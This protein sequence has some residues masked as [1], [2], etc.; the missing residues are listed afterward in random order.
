MGLAALAC[1]LDVQAGGVIL[2]RSQAATAA[3]CRQGGV[4]WLGAGGKACPVAARAPGGEI[5]TASAAGGRSVSAVPSRSNDEGRRQILQQELGQERARLAALQLAGAREP[6]A[7]DALQRARQDVLA[8][9]RE[10]ARLAP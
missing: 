10:L 5:A 2:E 8:L 7:A 9:E 3:S 1:A 6:G 4:E